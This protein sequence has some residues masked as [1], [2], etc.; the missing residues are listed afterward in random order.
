MTDVEKMEEKQA[1]RISSSSSLSSSALSGWPGRFMAGAIVQGAALVALTAILVIGSVSFMKPDVARVIAGGGAGTWFTFGYLM[2]IAVGVVSVA[3]SAL[4]YHLLVGT[5]K[6]SNLLAWTHLILM[7]VGIAAAAGMMM[8]AG[9]AGGAAALPAAVGGQGLDS[10]HVHEIIAPYVQPIGASILLALVGVVAGGA[11]Y[12]K[13]YR[14]ATDA[15]Q[16]ERR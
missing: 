2:Y 1:A 14:K 4:F 10:A 12:L 15:R 9:Y 7:N 3:V 11:G 6:I 8:Y 5:R 16:E 13:A